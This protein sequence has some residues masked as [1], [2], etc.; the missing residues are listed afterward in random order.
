MHMT[1][2]GVTTEAI[3][4]RTYA[5]ASAPFPL[6][7]Q[8]S[9]APRGSIATDIR[10]TASACGCATAIS[11]LPLNFPEKLLAILPDPDD[12][13]REVLLRDVVVLLHHPLPFCG[14]CCLFAPFEVVL[15]RPLHFRL[16]E[17]AQLVRPLPLLLTVVDR[18]RAFV[19]NDLVSLH[20]RHFIQLV[21][22]ASMEN[23]S[24]HN[25]R[26]V[27]VCRE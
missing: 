24:K 1:V 19:R 22:E 11:L 17:L 23:Q 21:G 27:H 20:L 15:E 3:A 12:C 16:L 5:A 14:A 6:H 2:G 7:F 9:F 26:S 4:I 10:S 18:L 13:A 25:Y 8:L